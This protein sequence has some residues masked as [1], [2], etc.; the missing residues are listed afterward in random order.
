VDGGVVGIPDG[1]M[2]FSQMT[3]VSTPLTKTCE[4]KS[5]DPPADVYHNGA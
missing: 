2:A 4:F 3:P 1:Q 5:N